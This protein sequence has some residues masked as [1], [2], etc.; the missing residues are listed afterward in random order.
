MTYHIYNQDCLD[1]MRSQPS[2]QF[3]TIVTSPPYNL[4]G[5]RGDPKNPSGFWNKSIINYG[6]HDDNMD[7]NDYKNWQIDIINECL[8][9][10]KPNGSFF[11]QHKVRKWNKKSS[12]PMEWILRSDAILYQEIIWN[13]KLTI[14]KDPNYLMSTTESIYWLVKGEPTVYRKQIPNEFRTTIWTICPDIKNKHPAPYPELLPEL[15][16]KLTSKEN[17][18]IYDP[19]SGSGTTV[20]AAMKTN[21][22]GYGTE[23]SSIFYQQSL[24]RLSQN[25]NN[26]QIFNGLFEECR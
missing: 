15:C 19:F 6:D 5:F 13:R 25:D 20:L 16:I 14:A 3:Q 17:D 18:L 7:E 21:R 22:I 23:L 2:D 9:L 10:L 26:K 4:R 24:E 11:Y 8:R 1:W 12:H